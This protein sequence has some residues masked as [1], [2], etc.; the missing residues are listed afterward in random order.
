MKGDRPL[1][2]HYRRKAKERQWI[3]SIS[4]WRRHF[5]GKGLVAGGVGGTATSAVIASPT[6]W[7]VAKD[8]INEKVLRE[9]AGA[10]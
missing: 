10:S 7:Q 2:N 6:A 4:E 3:E 9:E 5:T 1:K 8:E